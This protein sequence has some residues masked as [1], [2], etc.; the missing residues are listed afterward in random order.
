MRKMTEIE[1]ELILDIE[2]YLSVKKG[3]RRG[4][5]CIAKRFIKASKK[6]MESH[7]GIK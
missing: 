7:D 2:M 5:F 1:L 3:M 4:I 6:D